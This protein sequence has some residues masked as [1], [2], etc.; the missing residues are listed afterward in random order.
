VH[1]SEK[2]KAVSWKLVTRSAGRVER[3][4]FETAGEAFDALEQ[5][6]RALANTERRDAIKVAKRTYEPSAQVALRAELRGP[7]GVSGGVDVHGDGTAS[8]YTGR[9][10]RE[11]LDPG[12]GE[13]EYAALRR[14]LAA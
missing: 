11:P 2:V 8:A 13:S 1:A 9:W 10:R 6:C 4:R 5:E 12:K 14:A 3:R 7:K